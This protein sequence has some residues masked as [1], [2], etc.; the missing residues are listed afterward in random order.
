MPWPTI[1]INFDNVP[2]KS[3]VGFLPIYIRGRYHAL[4]AIGTYIRSYMV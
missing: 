2:N 1:E 4:E 3:K